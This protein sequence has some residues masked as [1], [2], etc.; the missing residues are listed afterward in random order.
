MIE[1][2]TMRLEEIGENR[3]RIC[4]VVIEEKSGFDGESNSFVQ[5]LCCY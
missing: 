4:R 3:L 1:Y 2:S 5:T